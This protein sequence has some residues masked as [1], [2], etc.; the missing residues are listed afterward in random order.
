MHIHPLAIVSPDAQIGSGVT[1]GP[2]AV[3]ESD[4]VIGDDCRIAAHA[5]I[6]DGTTLGPGNEIGEAAI[7]GGHP[8]HLKK[9]DELGRLVIGTGNTIREHATLHRALRPGTATVVGNHNM[10]MVGA[11]VAHDCV[12][13]DR[14]VIA[15]NV[16]LA[17][18]VVVE[19]CAFL[20]GG[21]GI[22][23]FC[24]IGTLAMVGGLARVIQDVPPYTLI[25]GASGC[26][27]GLN[28]VGLR[29]NGYTVEQV[30]ELK[31]AYRII[32]RRGMKWTDILETLQ[33]TFSA[34]PATAFHR[35]L[36]GGKRGFVQERRLP[37]GATIKLRP[38][39]DES[40]DL[41]QSPS[42]PLPELQS[43]AG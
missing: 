29:R 12:V 23:Q 1:I 26:V 14:I 39:A 40:A 9:P 5:V 16:L 38:P 33:A 18:H 3:V 31:Q 35:F 37:P 17:G 28:L 19:D 11:H 7:V 42:L 34:A 43:K 25:D 2:F 13:G 15:N 24:R 27:V 32:Y 22:H 36:S 8:Q 30:N 41:E 20:S 10:M 21:V 6:K 4:V